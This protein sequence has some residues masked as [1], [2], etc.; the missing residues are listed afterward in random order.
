M[1]STTATQSDTASVLSSVFIIAQRDTEKRE[2]L[3][4]W[5]ENKSGTATF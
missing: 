3:I 2:Y 4:N 1:S 5:L